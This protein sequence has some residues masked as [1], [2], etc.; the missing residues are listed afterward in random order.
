MHPEQVKHR[1]VVHYSHFLRSLRK[2]AKHY[3]VGKSTLSRWVKQSPGG[4]V[5]RRSR[6]R[7][8][9]A[10]SDT[11][12]ETVT[13]KPFSTADTIIARVREALGKDVSRSTMYRSL[14]ALKHSYKRAS[15]GREH[16]AVPW[17]HPFM[18]GDSYEG[19]P[20]AVD[21]SSFYWN[22]FPRMGW[23]PKGKRVKKAR[24]RDRK[25]VSLLLAVGK[26]GV[27]AYAVL[28]GGVRSTHFTDFVRKLPDGRPVIL[29]NCS[30][31]KTKEVRALCATKGITLRF[32]PPYCPWY[33]PAEFCF[34]E[35]K[36]AYRPL[37]LETPAADFVDDVIA[38]LEGLKHQRSYFD[39]A[40]NACARD[41]ASARP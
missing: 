5:R 20:I 21:E 15:R 35:I 2:V 28:V 11:V 40:A 13:A 27:V 22:D 19:D 12:R 25:R 4:S 1:A 29:D 9:D 38:C 31:H 41:R 33:N 24:P 17:S 3:N 34:S 7:L 23:G 10:I 32:I 39:H 14:H 16:E 37:R 36:R 26:E 30:I 18:A 6:K 8:Y